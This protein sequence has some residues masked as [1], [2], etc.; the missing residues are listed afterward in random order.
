MAN[1]AKKIE[2]DALTVRRLTGAARLLYEAFR[3]CRDRVLDK[4]TSHG[5]PLINMA[6]GVGLR[7]M[8]LEGTSLSIVTTRA[9]LSRQAVVKVAGHLEELGYMTASRDPT[10][11]L[12]QSR[13]T[14]PCPHPSHY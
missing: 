11:D 10:K 9:G 14:M 2:L 13:E 6:H 1:R 8:N 5:H 12:I 7:D 3:V 4:S